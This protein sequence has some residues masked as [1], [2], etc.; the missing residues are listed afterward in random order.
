MQ[1][2]KKRK[3]TKKGPLA[4]DEE[5]VAGFG[6]ETLK[7]GARSTCRLVTPFTHVY[8]IVTEGVNFDLARDARLRG[9]SPLGPGSRPTREELKEIQKTS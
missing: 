7:A 8:H 3:R 5:I 9:Q 1:T 6:H 4:E 2:G